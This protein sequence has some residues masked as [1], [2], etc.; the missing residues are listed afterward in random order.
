MASLTDIQQQVLDILA[1]GD[2]HTRGFEGSVDASYTAIQYSLKKLVR[3]G[4]ATS[5]Y[6]IVDKREPSRLIYSITLLGLENTTRVRHFKVVNNIQRDL[7]DAAILGTNPSSFG[8]GG[9]GLGSY[10]VNDVTCPECG[11]TGPVTFPV[12]PNETFPSLR[13]WWCSSCEEGFGMMVT[14]DKKELKRGDLQ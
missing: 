13:M 10:V 5:E 7:L 8:P 14:E 6:K 3:L 4:F 1:H 11:K 2:L 9:F 12:L